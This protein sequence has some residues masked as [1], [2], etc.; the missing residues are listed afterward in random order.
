[1]KPFQQI[2][3][4]IENDVDILAEKTPSTLSRMSLKL[5]SFNQSCL[6]TPVN[7][8]SGHPSPSYERIPEV[9]RAVLDR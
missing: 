9:R 3:C 7:P 5:G 2:L 4:S 1:M 8:K 6:T